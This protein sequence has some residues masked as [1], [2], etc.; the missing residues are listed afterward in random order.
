MKGAGSDCAT[1]SRITS[2]GL[3]PKV[4][5]RASKGERQARGE[6]ASPRAATSRAL[7]HLI[8]FGLVVRAKDKDGQERRRYWQLTPQGVEVARALFPEEKLDPDLVPKLK[9]IFDERLRRGERRLPPW[10]EFYAL[11]MCLN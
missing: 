5:L 2:G 7:R 11:C 6:L 10:E 4:F 1:F 9:E 8:G 3:E